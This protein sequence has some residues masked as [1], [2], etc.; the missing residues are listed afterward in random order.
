MNDTMTWRIHRIT[1][2]FNISHA[3]AT[4]APGCPQGPHPTRWCACKVHRTQAE[5]LAYIEQQ[6]EA[7]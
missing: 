3:W 2:A 7:A 1:H 6:K 5:A 4:T